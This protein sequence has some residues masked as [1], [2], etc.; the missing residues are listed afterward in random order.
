[1]H[2]AKIYLAIEVLL[3]PL[4]I[5]FASQGFRSVSRHFRSG[6]ISSSSIMG[7]C[8]LF[9][10]VVWGLIG[11]GLCVFGYI[12]NVLSVFALQREIRTPTTTLLQSLA[13]SDLVLLLSVCI[14]DAV[15]YICA[16]TGACSDPWEVLHLSHIIITVTDY[17]LVIV[18]VLR[19]RSMSCQQKSYLKPE[20]L[21]EA[22]RVFLFIKFDEPLTT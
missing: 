10:F 16:Y 1:M 3:S 7:Q 22:V 4:F 13:I 18:K 8:V 15:P 17:K 9:N 21:L 2:Y 12:G 5:L 11:S 19:K 20:I 6:F 14:T